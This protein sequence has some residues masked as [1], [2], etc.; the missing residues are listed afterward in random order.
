MYLGVK[1]ATLAGQ[2]R[3]DIPPAAI[4]AR[5]GNVTSPSLQNRS[6]T[7]RNWE[8]MTDDYR[9]VNRANWDE[10]VSLHAEAPEYALGRYLDDAN[11]IS[12]VV[13]FD[14]PLLGNVRGVEA[15]HLQCHLGTDTL[16]LH[17]L[18][19]RMSGLD[20]SA[21]ALERAR[22]LAHRTGADIDYRE[23]ELYDAVAVFGGSAFDLVF[24]GVGALCWIPDINR[25]A[26]V[27]RDLL[28]PNGRLFLREAHPVLWAVDDPRPDGLLA[29]EFPYFERPEP[30]V[31]EESGTYAGEERTL[32]NRRTL[33]WNHGLGE[34]VDA[35]IGAGLAPT[36]LVEHLSL[37]WNALPGQ[38]MRLDTGEWQLIDRPERMPHSY[39]LVAQ[40]R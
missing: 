40:Q 13:R 4:P 20:F 22:D 16:S 29:L 27:V 23:A 6:L 1:Q 38:M 15:V 12:D 26:G 5:E 21:P 19:A 10:R 11:Y 37:P 32:A 31:W 34:I 35:V 24:T 36:R 9:V 14:L 17:R 30:M 18:G 39:T 8:S 25:W 2:G 28:R 7:A 3:Q 33:A